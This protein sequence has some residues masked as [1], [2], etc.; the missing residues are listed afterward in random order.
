MGFRKCPTSEVVLGVSLKNNF[1]LKL[2]LEQSNK[3]QVRYPSKL[4]SH[5]LFDSH[6]L[7][8]Q[9]IYRFY[10]YRNSFKT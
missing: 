6:A 3:Y 10:N 8:A 5:F 2:S 9:I 1:R 7:N 4:V